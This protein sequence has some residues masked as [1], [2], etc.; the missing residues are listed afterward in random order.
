M[1]L[2]V[3][4][5]NVS[6]ARKKSTSIE[7]AA[8]AAMVMAARR[9][10]ERFVPKLEGW[11]RGTAHYQS[12]PEKG[13]LVY[14]DGSVTYAKPQYYGC[15]NKTEPGTTMRWFEHAKPIYLST[16]IKEGEK[17]AQEVAKRG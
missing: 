4:R 2:K 17:A 3:K 9:D 1:R 14:G 15:P 10:T 6:R 5:A 11:L 12:Y 16:W 8:N 13:Q 7:R